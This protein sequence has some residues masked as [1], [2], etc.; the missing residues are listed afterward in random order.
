MSKDSEKSF[1]K[2]FG[3]TVLI[4][5]VTTVLTTVVTLFVTKAIHIISPEENRVVIL[6][7]L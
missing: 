5:I 6:C 4:T 3:G 1:W 2:G 7:E